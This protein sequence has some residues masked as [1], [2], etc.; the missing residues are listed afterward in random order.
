M[1]YDLALYD[2]W[3][4]FLQC[5]LP[6]NSARADPY[7]KNMVSVDV[8]IF[9]IFPVQYLVGII[10]S[11]S[12]S[13][14][15]HIPSAYHQNFIRYQIDLYW[16]KSALVALNHSGN[17]VRCFWDCYTKYSFVECCE[18]EVLTRVE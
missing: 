3:F 16:I 10:M 7:P 4:I 1:W 6:L 15:L 8:E 13:F 5:M 12:E 11:Y 9:F 18:L 14:S 17:R 2:H